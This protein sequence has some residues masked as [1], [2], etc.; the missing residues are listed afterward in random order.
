MASDPVPDDLLKIFRRF[1]SADD[2]ELHV[3]TLWVIHT[4]C[5]LNTASYT[6]YLCVT[7]AEKGSGKTRVL[8]VLKHLVRNP[9]MTASISPAALARTVDDQRPCIL[10]DEYDAAFKGDQELAEMLRGIL[11]SGFHISGSYTRLVGHGTNMKPQHFATFCPKALAGI[12]QLPDTLASRSL[13]I[14]LKRVPRGECQSFRPDGMGQTAKALRA[15]LTNLKNKAAAWGKANLQ[16]VANSEPACPDEFLDRQRDIS[17]PLLA[18][19]DL[20]G[21]EWPTNARR[22][23]TQIFASPAAEDRSKKAQLLADIRKI[24]TD[25]DKDKL[26]TADL[27]R[28]LCEIESSPW[29]EWS[30]GKHIT[31][32]A[33]SRLLRDFDIAPKSLRD[34]GAPFKGYEKSMFEDA[35]KR[36]LPD[37]RNG[38][39]GVL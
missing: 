6:P 39:E 32:Y 38:S 35:W 2:A 13:I 31:P 37:A 18:I 14:R 1:V 10:L 3:L 7:S 12:G 29:C 27:I 26:P 15:E 23:L 28:L 36:Y 17:E 25:E 8:D 16:A 19:A 5:F 4:H 11:N 9:L 20:L 33:L 34:G 24:F 22:A 30:H 21:G